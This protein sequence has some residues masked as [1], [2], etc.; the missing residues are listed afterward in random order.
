M[1]AIDHKTTMTKAELYNKM[2]EKNYALAVLEKELKL[3]I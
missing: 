1:P 3:H 2:K